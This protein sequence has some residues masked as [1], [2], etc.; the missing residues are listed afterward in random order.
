MDIP[1][2]PSFYHD[3]IEFD[4]KNYIPF[5][6]GA[7]FLLIPFVYFDKGITQQQVSVIIGAAD[8]ALIY[9]LL[10]MFTSKRNSILLSLF[11]GLGT[12]FFW[13]AVVGTTWFFAHVVA[14]FYITISLLLH[15]NRKHLLSG[16]FFA[17][18]ALT[19]MPMIVAGFFYLFQ[20]IKYK[21]KF[22]LFL[23]G[24][25]IFIPVFLYYNFLR[26]GNIYETGYG[27]VYEQYNNSKLKVSISKSFGY[28]NY[29]NIPTHLY[30]FFIMPP[31]IDIVDGTVKMIKPSP[32]GMGILF[33]SPLLLLAL[34]PKFKR[35]IELQSFITAALCSLPSFFHYS[36]GWVQFGYRFVLD[37]IVFLMIILALRFKPTKTN[38]FL[39]L[40]SVIVNYWGVLWAIELGW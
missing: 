2:L 34:L 24:A 10:S 28:F 40:I 1:D 29:K 22:A 19:R 26:F 35:G 18:A 13:S 4:G 37:F 16:I 30:T 17:L 38:I 9:I 5:P 36:Q 11:F 3:K 27:K 32:F 20:L 33:T 7:S 6:P 8:I 21:G 23:I 15:F 25:F 14:I 31:D 39:I 12:S